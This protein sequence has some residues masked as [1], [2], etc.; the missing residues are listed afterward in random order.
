MTSRP[1]RCCSPCRLVS[2]RR[3]AARDEAQALARKVVVLTR[4]T[5][6]PAFR[7]RHAARP[8]RRARGLTRR[9]DRS[10]RGGP[11]PVRAEAAPA[12]H[13]Q[14]RSR[15]GRARRRESAAGRTTPIRR[16]ARAKPKLSTAN[17]LRLTTRGQHQGHR[18]KDFGAVMPAQPASP[19]HQPSAN[20]RTPRTTTPSRPTPEEGA[21]GGTSL[22]PPWFYPR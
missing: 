3:V 8:R 19:L 4:E 18:N 16:L 12:R 5:D 11:L 13:S 20:Q 14:S 15:P 2:W 1:R 7:G 21:H 6:A 22:V 9:A 17:D 10:A